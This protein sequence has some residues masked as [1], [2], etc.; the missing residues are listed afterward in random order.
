MTPIV[1]EPKLLSGSESWV[2]WGIQ[3]LNPK[4]QAA[5]ILR[6]AER[7]RFGSGQVE[8]GFG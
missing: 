4:L 5:A 2:D 3:K 7:D 1:A 6:P 8:V